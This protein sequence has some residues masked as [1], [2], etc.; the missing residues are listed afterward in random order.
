MHGDPCNH[1]CE[2]VLV[3]LE[4]THPEL[5]GLS[6][7]LLLL[8]VV[9]T[10]FEIERLKGCLML[11]RGTGLKHSNRHMV[12]L[13]IGLTVRWLKEQLLYLLG[14]FIFALLVSLTITFSLLI[15]AFV[16][17]PEIRHFAAS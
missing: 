14:K 4:R 3:S 8:T 11:D 12:A 9:H 6:S 10:G 17:P 13:L 15:H 7:P 1:N 5:K 16:K 2:K